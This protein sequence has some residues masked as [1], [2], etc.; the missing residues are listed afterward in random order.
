MMLSWLGRLVSVRGGHVDVGFVFDEVEQAQSGICVLQFSHFI[1]AG[2]SQ[3][4]V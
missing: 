4:R 1:S 3:M 2:N